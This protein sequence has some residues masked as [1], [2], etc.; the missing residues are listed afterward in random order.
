[1]EGYLVAHVLLALDGEAKLRVREGEEL[2]GPL[3]EVI[4]FE[5][6]AAQDAVLRR[7]HWAEQGAA[8]HAGGVDGVGGDEATVGRGASILVLG[9][10]GIFPFGLLPRALWP[11]HHDGHFEIG[12]LIRVLKCS[13]NKTGKNRRIRW[14]ISASQLLY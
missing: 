10:L 4:D 14:L 11:P 2:A 1:M 12:S 5:G 6:G 8:V 9:S 13:G 7:R 3:K